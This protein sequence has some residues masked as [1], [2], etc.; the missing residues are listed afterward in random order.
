MHIS[1][2]AGCL[3]LCTSALLL[4]GCTSTPDEPAASEPGVY[5]TPLDASKPEPTFVATDAPQTTAAG[6]D[7]TVQITYFGWNPD[8]AAVELGGFVASVVEADGTCTLTLT[9]GQDS[10]TTS[11]AATPNVSNTACGEQLLPGD[12]LSSGTWSA[13]LSYDSPTSH[14]VSEPVEVEVP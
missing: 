5:G 8:A 6:D 14:G 2:R 11:T 12:R 7:V 3:A 1:R 13:V 4:A 10:Q 9:K